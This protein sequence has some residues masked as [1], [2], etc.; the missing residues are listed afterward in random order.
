MTRDK[1]A[2]PLDIPRSRRETYW[3]HYETIAHGTIRL[4][5]VE[6]SQKM[7]RLNNE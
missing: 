3:K 4:M 5:L 6:S 1:V 2:V 7:E